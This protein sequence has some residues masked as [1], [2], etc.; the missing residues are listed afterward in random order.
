MNS[1][2][3][4]QLLG[5]CIVAV[6][7]I[8]VADTAMNHLGDMAVVLFTYVFSQIGL[9]LLRHGLGTENHIM[10][11][12]GHVMALSWLTLF[13]LILIMPTWELTRIF[14]HDMLRTSAFM[15]GMFASLVI[16]GIQVVLIHIENTQVSTM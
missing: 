11:T 8:L 12:I 1:F 14:D 3:K 10:T 15:A 7:W 16:T 6:T 2:L 13:G 5:G 4:T 9:S